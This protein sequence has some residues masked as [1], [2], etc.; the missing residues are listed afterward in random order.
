MYSLFTLARKYVWYRFTASNGKGHGIHSPF[1]F[2][3]VAK[4]LQDKTVCPAYA[5]IEA[6]RR[7]LLQDKTMLNITDFG[8]GSALLKTQQRSVSQI[9]ASSLKPKKYAQLLHRMV[10]YYQPSTIL[11]LGT[12]LGITTAYLASGNSSSKVISCEGSEAI[13]AVAHQVWADLSINN[14]SAVEGSFETT[15]PQ[16]LEKVAVID[17]AFV[18]GNH[19]KVP[20]L[21]YF[22]VLLER[23]PETGIL[24]FDDIHWSA[25]M[26]SA[27]AEIQSHP[28]VTLSIDLFFI[29]VIKIDPA[30]KVKQQFRIAF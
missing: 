10:R 17:F 18:D 4:V 11:E 15:L 3:F 22:N 14:I 13:A 8:A 19:R 16:V 12:S 25:E 9:A 26:E 21:E 29:G 5:S 23:L 30:I 1:V 20:T 2:E 28:R 7:L 27:W 24:V 6:Q